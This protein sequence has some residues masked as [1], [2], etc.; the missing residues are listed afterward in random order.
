MLLFCGLKGKFRIGVNVGVESA[1]FLCVCMQ[2]TTLNIY[3]NILVIMLKM[4][5]IQRCCAVV[6]NESIVNV[7]KLT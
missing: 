7:T 2:R 5:S 4:G 6:V 1:L 3:G